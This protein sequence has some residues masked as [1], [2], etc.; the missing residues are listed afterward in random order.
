MD[1]IAPIVDAQDDEV[2]ERD[3]PF[4][5]YRFAA[6]E[7]A[8]AIVAE[9][10][11]L[12]LNFEAYFG[13][14]KN[15]RRAKDQETFDLTV[16]AILSDLMHHHLVGED[17]SIYVTRS[18]RV[19][20]TKSRYRPR[21]YSKMFPY[22]LD[23][24]AKPEMGF[25]VQDVAPAVE[26]LARSTVVQAG[27]R[28]LSRI[29]EREI[30][31]DDLGEHP[32]GET[33]ILKRTKDVDDYW[34]DGGWQEYEDTAVTDQ[35]RLEVDHIN[36][37]LASAD[38]RFEN[39]GI[40]WPQTTFHI[41]DRQLRRVFTQGRFD[42]GGRLFGG[43][44]QR[45][46]KHERRQGLWISG[47][48]AVELDYG[49]VGPRIVYALSGQKPPTDDLYHLWGY[50]Q[51]RDGIKRVMNAMIFAS[52]R[53]DR[54]PKGTRKLF[55]R[56]DKIGEVVEAIEAKHP[57][58]KDSFHRGLGHET[59]FVE[60]QIMVEVVLTLKAEGIVALPIHDAVLVPATK[61]STATE[62]MLSAFRRHTGVEGIVTEE[63]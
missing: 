32:H 42:S 49:Q 14:K 43:F 26:G 15:K 56:S 10:I 35:F 11:G 16:D 59:Q 33:I 44:W 55:R 8:K 47:E 48:K 17:G 38:L 21:A 60:S 34:D 1:Q 3:R 30:G 6:S 12:L 58:I 31:L 13:L 27:Q 22:I 57:L 18:N 45:L 50:T 41:R 20:G 9:V 25:V 19:L 40:A 2:E 53:L 37:W 63:A 62:I 4:N 28:L 36:Q 29:D 24:L 7:N 61:T 54:F 51:Q 46:R 39:T 23:L 5:A 52:E